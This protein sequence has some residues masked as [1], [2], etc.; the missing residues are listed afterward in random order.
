[1]AVGR[2]L[3]TRDL[4]AGRTAWVVQQSPSQPA[5]MK[6]FTLQ[7]ITSRLSCCLKLT[8][9]TVPNL[10]GAKNKNNR[11]ASKH[12]DEEHYGNF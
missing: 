10:D 7:P 6:P 1:M 9:F 4:N 12:G 2:Y 5:K 11:G 3:L 8:S